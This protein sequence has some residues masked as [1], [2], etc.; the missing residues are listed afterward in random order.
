METSRTE[1][2]HAVPQ[3]G[4]HSQKALRT[5]NSN[6]FGEVQMFG[7]APNLGNKR[8]HITRKTNELKRCIASRKG[9]ARAATERADTS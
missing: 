2:G 6:L 4:G 3:Q 1:G 8:K 9:R 5:P 7:E